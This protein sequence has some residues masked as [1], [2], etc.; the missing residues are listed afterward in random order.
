MTPRAGA[1]RA[2]WRQRTSRERAYLAVMAVAL[3]LFAYAFAVVSPLRSLAAQAERRHAI[4]QSEEAS[5]PGVLAELAQRE[6]VR[7]AGAD[8]GTLVQ[9][10]VAAGIVVS[11]DAGAAPGRVTLRFEAVPA[12]A[13]F[14]WLAAVRESQGLRPVKASIR[15]GSAGLDGEVTFAV[16]G[17]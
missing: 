10:A 17:T 1:W 3:A 7:A 16:A 11:Q 5:F 14:A 13:L 6:P 9:S 8:A 4:A 2:F 15:R 12:Q